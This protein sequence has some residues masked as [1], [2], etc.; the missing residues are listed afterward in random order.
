MNGPFNQRQPVALFSLPQEFEAL[1]PPPLLLPGE[2][3]ERFQLLRQT[4]LAELAPRSAIEWLLAIDVVELSWDIE[5]YRMLRHKILENHRQHAIEHALSRID[6]IGLEPVLDREATY[7]TRLNAMNWRT[8]KTATK[9][10]EARLAVHG[11]DQHSINAE[12]YTQAHELFLMF[13]TLLVAAQ[14]RR[15]TLLRE[16]SN[17]R[18]QAKSF[19]KSALPDKCS[20]DL[21]AKRHPAE[22]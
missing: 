9:E 20:N 21:A 4:I 18:R 5:R 3:L 16:I 12:V 8:C 17:N 6:V 14:T 10:I 11:F 2:S 19:E 15:M 1:A 13:E 22:P 7:R